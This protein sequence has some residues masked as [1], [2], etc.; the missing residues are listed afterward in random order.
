MQT[1][2]VS[3][4]LRIAI[5][6]ASGYA[7]AELVRLLAEHPA[8]RIDRPPR[9][10]PRRGGAGREFPHLAPLG[11]RFVDGEPEAGIDVAFLALPHGRSAELAV[12]LAA[13]GT[14]VIDIG[15]DLRLRRSGCLPGL[16]RLRPSG[17][18]CPGRCGLRAHRVRA[19]PAARR[20]LVGNPGCYPPRRSS[21]SRRSPVPACWTGD[22]VVDAKSG[23]RGAG[24]ERGRRLPLHRARGRHEGLRHPAAPAHPGDRPG[25]R[26]RRRGRA[27]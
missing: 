10:G 24:R 8:V 6:G 18:R 19:R 12:R 21:L 4:P 13:A 14:T 3:T 20:R 22:V 1:M 23:V 11:L 9:T 17:A 16:V 25:P 15:S 27:S 5:V 26:R 7:G 2:Q